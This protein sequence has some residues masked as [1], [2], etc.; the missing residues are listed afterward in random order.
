MQRPELAKVSLTFNLLM[1]TPWK[2]HSCSMTRNSLHF[3]HGRFELFA[4]KARNVTVQSDHG[5]LLVWIQGNSLC[6][7]GQASYLAELPPRS[8]RSVNGSHLRQHQ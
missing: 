1:R 2:L 4:R 7:G 5:L 8:L 3:Y 6:K